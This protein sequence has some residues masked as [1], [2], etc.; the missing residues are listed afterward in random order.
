MKYTVNRIEDKYLV[1]ENDLEQIIK[2]PIELIP[3]AKENDIV[4]IN[5]DHE[6]RKKQEDRIN[7]LIDEVF[8]D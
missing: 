7:G 8:I 2:V 1:L 5:I 4:T 3:E 6:E